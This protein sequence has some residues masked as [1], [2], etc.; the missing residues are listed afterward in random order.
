L[1]W[2]RQG[3]RWKRRTSGSGAGHFGN[4]AA[5]KTEKMTATIQTTVLTVSL[6]GSAGSLA[7]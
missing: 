6:S 3:S 4:R 1:R 7:L 5:S 2:E